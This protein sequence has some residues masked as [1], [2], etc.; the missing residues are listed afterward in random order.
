MLTNRRFPIRKLAGLGIVLAGL[1]VL[2]P[3]PAVTAGPLDVGRSF[4]G[5]LLD[6]P[7]TLAAPGL[8]F[9]LVFR[10]APRREDIVLR[11]ASAYEAASCRH[12]P[13]PVFGS[14]TE[15]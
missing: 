2:S 12:V 9:S 10:A 1:L 15:T 13:S 5:V 8:P 4:Y 14:I 3:A 6:T 7:T 11:I